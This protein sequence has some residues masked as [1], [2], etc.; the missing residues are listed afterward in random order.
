[1][2]TIKVFKFLAMFEQNFTVLPQIPDFG[3]IHLEIIA[4][5]SCKIINYHS[6]KFNAYIKKWTIKPFFDNDPLYYKEYSASRVVAAYER[7]RL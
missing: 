2:N 1:M 3:P 7:L 6:A 4:N 5:I